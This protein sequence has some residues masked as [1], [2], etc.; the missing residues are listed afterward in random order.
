MRE[1]ALPDGFSHLDALLLPVV[2]QAS[3]EVQEVEAAAEDTAD[4][5]E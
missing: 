3:D 1:W 5:A 4:G 2:C